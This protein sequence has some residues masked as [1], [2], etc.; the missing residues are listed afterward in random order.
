[1]SVVEK[2]VLLVSAMVEKK[3]VLTVDKRVGQWASN[4]AE[5]LVYDRVVSMAFSKAGLLVSLLALAMAFD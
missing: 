2:V 5:L 3:V 1:L 4:L